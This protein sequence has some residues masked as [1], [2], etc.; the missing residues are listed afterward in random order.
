MCVAT[1]TVPKW[2]GWQN[3]SGCDR[4]DVRLSVADRG[5]LRADR[6]WWH[7]CC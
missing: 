6:D 2:C 3:G 1:K 5:P 7:W 4:A